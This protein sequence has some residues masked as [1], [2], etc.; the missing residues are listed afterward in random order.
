MGLGVQSA[1]P[2]LGWGAGGWG[3]EA[4]GT[5]RSASESTVS[6]DNSSWNLSLWGED[7]LAT[8]RGGAIYYWDTS[9]GIADRAV[10]A[11]SIAGAQSVPS[12]V[13]VTTV[14][15]PDRHFIAGGCTSYSSGN[16]DNM[17]VRWSSQEEFTKFAPTAVNTAGDQRLEIGTKSWRW[18]LPV[19]KR[20]YL[21]MKLC[22]A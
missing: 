19:K 11:S 9:G 1:A 10:L 6:L 18:F 3:N 8:V 17:L 7:L 20:S 4:W 2:A 12:V 22:M 5:P 15:F 16:V 21:Q 14:S 13:R